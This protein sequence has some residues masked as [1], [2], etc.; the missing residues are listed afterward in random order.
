VISLFFA[1]RSFYGMRITSTGSETPK[2]DSP[3]AESPKSEPI[4][5]KAEAKADEKKDE[6]SASA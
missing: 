2:S 5:D 3:T 1:W 6:A 4:G